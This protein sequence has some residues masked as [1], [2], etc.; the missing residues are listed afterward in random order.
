MKTYIKNLKEK[1]ESHRTR[2]A[3]GVASGVT[4]VVFLVWISTLGVRLSSGGSLTVDNAAQSSVAAVPFSG[5][6]IEEQLQLLQQN[7]GTVKENISDFRS[8]YQEL[9]STTQSDASLEAEVSGEE[10]T[11]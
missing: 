2:I 11:Y 8:S 3:F 1:P 7:F 5:G 4:A 10:Q 6:G 9:S